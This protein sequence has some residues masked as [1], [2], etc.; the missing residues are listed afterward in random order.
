MGRIHNTSANKQFLQ[1]TYHHSKLKIIN[2]LSC[3]F[4]ANIS[5]NSAVG[6]S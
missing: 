4:K 3:F 2:D 6:T 1:A 5:N